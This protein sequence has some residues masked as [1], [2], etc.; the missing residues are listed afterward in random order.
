MLVLSRRL[1]ESI[2][3]D[4]SIRITVLSIRGNQVRLGIE[5]PSRV[6]V[7]REELL[8]GVWPSDAD[9]SRAVQP[10]SGA[11]GPIRRGR[12]ILA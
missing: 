11:D 10:T 8:G 1:N 3:I 12:R 9:D 2:V 5:A 4:E 6:A 7:Y